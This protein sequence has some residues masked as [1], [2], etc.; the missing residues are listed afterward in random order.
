MPPMP[1]AFLV[2]VWSLVCSVM[3]VLNAKPKQNEVTIA[4]RSNIGFFILVGFIFAVGLV[5]KHRFI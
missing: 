1:V 4:E 3:I 5:R 2:F